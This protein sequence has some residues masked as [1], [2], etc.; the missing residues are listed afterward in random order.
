MAQEFTLE[1]FNAALTRL[2]KYGGYGALSSGFINPQRNV[3]KMQ[4][5][6]EW[7]L[8]T[9]ANVVN[10]VGGGNLFGGK[11]GDDE[12][13]KEHKGGI[14]EH[15][16][17]DQPIFPKTNQGHKN[18]LD[19]LFTNQ[20]KTGYSPEEIMRLGAEFQK[21]IPIV[22]PTVG[23]GVGSENTIGKPIGFPPKSEVKPHLDGGEF[24]DDR[25]KV[26]ETPIYD[27]DE[28]DKVI[29]YNPPVVDN[30]LTTP[31][32]TGRAD[33]KL[34]EIANE[35]EEVEKARV[36]ERQRKEGTE[37]LS[38]LEQEE[39]KGGGP[40][41]ATLG[42]TVTPGGTTRTIGTHSDPR[43]AVANVANVA[44]DRDAGAI[45]EGLD[46]NT[47]AE[48]EGVTAQAN[49][50]LTSK[51]WSDSGNWGYARTRNM[52]TGGGLGPVVTEGALVPWKSQRQDASSADYISNVGGQDIFPSRLSE[53]DRLK[54][55]S[56]G[57]LSFVPE[58]QREGWKKPIM[59]NEIGPGNNAGGEGRTPFNDSLSIIDGIDASDLAKIRNNYSTLRDN[60]T[61]S[62][63]SGVKTLQGVKDVLSKVVSM[64]EDFI[65]FLGSKLGLTE[66]FAAGK[67]IATWLNT[68]I[69]A[70]STDQIGF[71]PLDIIVVAAAGLPALGT[72]VMGKAMNAIFKPVTEAIKGGVE[73]IFSFSGTTTVSDKQNVKDNLAH[74]NQSYGGQAAGMIDK[75]TYYSA[76]GQVLATNMQALDF[77]ASDAGSGAKFAQAVHN[78]ADSFM[79]DN[80]GAGWDPNTGEV[81]TYDKDGQK[82]R[83]GEYVVPNEANDKVY[84]GSNGDSKGSKVEWGFPIISVT[85]M[86]MVSGSRGDKKGDKKD[87]TKGGSIWDWI[88][89]KDKKDGED[90]NEEVAD[91]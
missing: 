6:G 18:Y 71:T 17:F 20:A 29:P 14:G 42:A 33:D 79:P 89:P 3:V 64:P 77:G 31:P 91:N 58:S 80:T 35:L 41:E 74:I 1:D 76:N 36:V 54:S 65:D 43:D 2:P 86:E 60:V 48:L 7:E 87:G 68:P 61:A 32:P 19:W 75:G 83:T 72:V 8:E 25:N 85:P 47:K 34:R 46:D 57:E 26:I 45:I 67:D 28:R 55:G 52:L 69:D 22:T 53:A 24:I 88:W 13:G 4:P 50:L 44:D 23:A 9:G 37:F 78:I 81:I 59:L 10:P 49:K 56:G 84:Q 16:A 27:V 66:T 70:I 15:L 30:A 82:V 51:G 90:D 5:R 21:Q 12:G 38:Q 40:W 39:D 11:I 73:T 63:F 62:D